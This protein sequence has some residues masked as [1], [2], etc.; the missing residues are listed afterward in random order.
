MIFVVLGTQKFQCNRLLRLVDK[1]VEDG[2]IT[3]EVVAQRGYS[4]YSPQNYEFVDF[5][6]KEEFE[7]RINECSLLITHSGVGTILSGVYHHKPVI[8]FPRLKKYSEHVDDHQLDIA[9][10]FAKKNLVLM[11]G[12][13]DD[14]AQVIETSKTTVFDTYV[15]QRETMI[16]II[17]DYLEKEVR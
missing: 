16:G 14:M 15:S 6:Q 2:V 5:L 11:C 7:S 3:E 8:V 4:D 17:R 13:E 1:L 12:E 10:A 9:K